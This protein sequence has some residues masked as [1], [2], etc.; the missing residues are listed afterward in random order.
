MMKSILRISLNHISRKYFKQADL[1]IE[2]GSTSRRNLGTFASVG[3]LGGVLHGRALI[4]L[5]KYNTIITLTLVRLGLNAS[6]LF[7]T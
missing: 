6:Y 5:S 1:G 2:D 4:G 7:L 3:V